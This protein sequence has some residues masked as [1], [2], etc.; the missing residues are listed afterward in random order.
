M[1]A[2]RCHLRFNCK[3]S[4]RKIYLLS[5]PG[6]QNFFKSII[7]LWCC[8]CTGAVLI[9][10]EESAFDDGLYLAIKGSSASNRSGS[11]GSPYKPN[12]Q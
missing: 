11:N 9:I 12:L 7:A 5:I 8:C 6:E 10:I 2:I 1:F 3:F 4:E